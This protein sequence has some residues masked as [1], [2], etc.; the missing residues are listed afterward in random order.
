MK[1]KGNKGL[2]ASLGKSKAESAE[3]PAEEGDDEVAVATP[4]APQVASPKP[5]NTSAVLQHRQ[6]SMQAIAKGELVQKTMRLVDPA[7]CRMWNEHDRNYAL[8]NEENCDDLISGILEQGKQTTPATVRLLENDPTHKYEVICGARRHWVI[9][10]LRD[11]KKR[12]EYKFLVEVKDLNDEEA[13]RESDVENRARK[14]I[15]DYERAV[16][17][18]KGLKI[19]YKTQKDMAERIEMS[20]DAL[21]KYLN[22]AKLPREI[23][24][25][26]ASS[27]DIRV[28]HG[29]D[30][31][32]LL[33]DPA[34]RNKIINEAKQLKKL[35]TTRMQTNAPV[36]EGKDVVK[37]LLAA[38]KE[39]APRPA[40]APLATY[41]SG[42]GEAI[43]VVTKKDNKALHINLPLGQQ[44]SVD[45]LINAFTRAVAE[46]MKETAANA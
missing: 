13:F 46:H 23:V 41:N 15:S 5:T 29:I 1:G 16:K 21:S 9:T 38:V 27:N 10:Y 37:R 4:A 33:K 12:T 14:D 18:A 44:A 30:L 31:V 35:Q 3:V 32:P 6:T 22:L 24:E 34:Q 17:Y 2:F 19:H 40:A 26:Y 45:E 39:T 8:L 42:A 25:A 28:R 43:L 20:Q 11:V 7:E 36:L